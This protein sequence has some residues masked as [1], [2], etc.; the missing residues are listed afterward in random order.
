MGRSDQYIGLNKI[1]VEYLNN[2]SIEGTLVKREVIEL[3]GASDTLCG[4][5]IYGSKWLFVD[6]VGD[7]Y[8]VREVLQDSSH[9]NS[10]PMYFTCLADDSGLI[11]QWVYSSKLDDDDDDFDS[12]VGAIYITDDFNDYID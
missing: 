11:G 9:W 3:V 6:S 2:I 1:A 8:S 5:P 7:F 10:G 12:A 4:C